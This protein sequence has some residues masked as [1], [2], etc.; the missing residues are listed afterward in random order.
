MFTDQTRLLRDNPAQR[1]YGVAVTDVD[2]D[3]AFEW[4]VCG[5]GCP[6]QVLKWSGES[7]VGVTPG[8][9]ADGELQALG[10]AA[11]DLDG[12]GREEI[13]VLNSDTFAGP[14]RC[15]DRLY[16]WRSGRWL[17]LFEQPINAGVRNTTAGRSVAVLD[18]LGRGKYGFVVASFDG[19]MRFYEEENRQLFDVAGEAGL[20]RSAQSR[21]LLALPLFADGMD[22]LVTNEDGPNFLYR[23]HEDGTY[24]EVAAE[25]GLDD[26]GEHGRGVAALDHPGC[27]RFAL[28]VGNWEG[29]HRL[30]FPGDQ[31]RYRNVASP[32]LAM[33]SRI[34]TVLAADFDNDGFQEIFF[35]NLGEPN[36]LFGWRDGRWS[37]LDSGAALEPFAAGTGAAVGDLDGDGRL[38]LLIA[39]GESGPAP[40]ALFHGPKNDHHWL[41]VQV[42]TRSGAPARGAVV[43]LMAEGR[44]QRRCIDAGSG[45]LCQMEPVAHF[46]LGRC[47]R[48]DWLQVRWPD[49]SHLHWRLPPCDQVLRVEYPR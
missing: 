31:G 26:P 38:E 1:R 33:P 17:D 12:D 47:R 40:L 9:L 35:N 19:A 43:T 29:L 28:V 7:F 37:P 27:E 20:L 39:H 48:V 15:A 16:A 22:L 41:R 11:G 45:Y 49:G 42:L 5:Y 21:G 13:Y 32:A 3:G 46:G 44:I 4:F 14:K 25:L 36:R 2:G 10:V 24:R 8:K 30:F 6:N 34:R 23:H 18:R